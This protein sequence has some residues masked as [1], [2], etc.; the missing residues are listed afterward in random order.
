MRPSKYH[1]VAGEVRCR[2]VVGLTVI[3]Y[4]LAPSKVD[5]TVVI[6]SAL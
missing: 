3:K 2:L 1:D 6:P 4:I 5:L